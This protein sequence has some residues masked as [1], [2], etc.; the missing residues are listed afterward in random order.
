MSPERPQKTRR[1]VGQCRGFRTRDCPASAPTIEL[2]NGG[3]LAH[4]SRRSE[5]ATETRSRREACPRHA[6][7]RRGSNIRV[8]RRIIGL[9]QCFHRSSRLQVLQ[10]GCRPHDLAKVVAAEKGLKR[11]A[12]R[13]AIVEWYHLLDHMLRWISTVANLSGERT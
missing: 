8:P 7:G 6:L 4:R 13:I 5:D 2:R 1:R 10:P 12:V 11:R 3:F 9:E